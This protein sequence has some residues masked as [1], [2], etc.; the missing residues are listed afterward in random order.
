M[1]RALMALALSGAVVI[2]SGTVAAMQKGHGGGPKPKAVGGGSTHAS[3]ARGPAIKSHGP[4]AAKGPKAPKGP[5]NH[6]HGGPKASG[7]KATLAKNSGSKTHAAKAP[8][9]KPTDTSVTTRTKK[10]DTTTVPETGSTTATLT[11]VQQKLQR[12]TNLANKLEGRLPAG[13]DLMTAAAG[14]RNLGQFVAALNVSNNLGISFTQLK[15]SMVTDGNSLGQ[16]IKTLRPSADSTTAVR[17]AETDANT[18]I[19]Q[20]EETTTTA[21][22]PKKPGGN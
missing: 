12:N 22:K 11:P 7:P 15:T 4:Q 1:K 10:G 13:T 5:S 20:T 14:F 8:K 19:T 9:T 2:T 6:A 21:K 17:R 3:T 16:S 18:L